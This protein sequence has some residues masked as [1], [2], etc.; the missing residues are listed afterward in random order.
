MGDGLQNWALE[1]N[2]GTPIVGKISNM[3]SIPRGSFYF[4]ARI[5]CPIVM[6][7]AKLSVLINL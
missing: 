2:H 5:S 6:A 1:I 7:F 4:S 3:Q